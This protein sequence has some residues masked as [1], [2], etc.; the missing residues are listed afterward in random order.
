MTWKE[1][2]RNIV[3]QY[4]RATATELCDVYGKCSA[5]KR[6]A[7]RNCKAEMV[8]RNGYGM[9]ILS[10]SCYFFTCAFRFEEYG[11]P[12]LMYFTHK[13]SEIIP[14]ETEMEGLKW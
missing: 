1:K 12:Y 9:R 6:K 7:F 5:E 8:N 4:N 10:A 13:G 3:R 2:Q 14:M 11:E